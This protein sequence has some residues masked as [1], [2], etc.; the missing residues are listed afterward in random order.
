MEVETMLEK[1]EYFPFEIESGILLKDIPGTKE[2]WTV[3][4][5]YKSAS[6]LP[7]PPV[8]AFQDPC[9]KGSPSRSRWDE[10]NRSEGRIFCPPNTQGAQTVSQILVAGSG[11]RVHNPPI[12]PVHGTEGVHQAP[13]PSCGF[14][15]VTWDP[16]CHIFG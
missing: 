12:W 11:I 7:A 5:C 9:G 6:S 4:A 10:Q 2:E 16:L 14:S 3:K 8:S 1:G 13:M 15:A